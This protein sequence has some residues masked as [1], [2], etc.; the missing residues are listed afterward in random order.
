MAAI[1]GDELR[2]GCMPPSD[3]KLFFDEVYDV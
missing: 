2:G 3:P 1:H